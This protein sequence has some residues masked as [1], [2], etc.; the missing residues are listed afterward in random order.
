MNA[1]TPKD[2]LDQA[3]RRPTGSQATN[4]EQ[5]RAVAEVQAMVIVAQRAPRNESIAIKK[6]LDSCSQFSVAS[7]A[8]YRFPRGGQQVTGE[9]IS[10][11]VEL[12]RCWGN[13]NYGIMELARDDSAAATE[14][15]AFAWDLE[16]N[17][18]STQTFIVP[19]KRDKRGGAELLTDMRDIYENNANNGARRLRECIFR[20]LPPFL[21]EAAKAR[22]LETIENG[23]A[24]QPLQVRIA[25]GIEAFGSI[26]VPL[27]RLEARF[28]PSSNWTGMDIAQMQVIYLSI[29]RGE[30][31]AA[32][33]FPVDTGQQARGI[34]QEIRDATGSSDARRK[35][36]KGKPDTDPV[37]E[38]LA[39]DLKQPIEEGRADDQHG[40]QHDGTDEGDGAD[41][42]S[43][44]ETLRLVD[45]FENVRNND[46]Y[47]AA[48][49]AFEKASPALSLE[50]KQR[51]E[52][53]IGDV[54]DRRRASEAT[55]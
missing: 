47:R 24:G 43:E 9:S 7:N 37:D 51:I 34:E 23:E 55:E 3:E 45:L 50:Q 31:D 14:M 49:A 2:I 17:T 25:S 30:C 42:P 54:E 21:K 29:R 18:R 52:K 33:E 44:V 8:F 27:P 15:L 16:T 38:S 32:D 10:L 46:M 26:G 40:D 48:L 12:A 53:A 35:R 11:A 39:A 13:I 5:S 41:S 19:H 22:C 6:A 20:V 28:G 1:P 36:G 4:I